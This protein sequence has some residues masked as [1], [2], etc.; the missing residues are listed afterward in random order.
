VSEKI[1][2]VVIVGSI[3]S[4]FETFGVFDSHSE[5]CDFVDEFVDGEDSA[6]MIVQGKER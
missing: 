4:G 5:A 1:K 3:S 2:Y 6:I